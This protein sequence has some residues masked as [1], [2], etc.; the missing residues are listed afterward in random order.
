[1]TTAVAERRTQAERRAA[2]RAKLL[3]AALESLAEL[4]YTG[5]SLPEVVRRAGLSNGGLWRHFRSKAEL[6]AAASLEAEERLLAASRA[7]V[8]EGRSVQERLDT[9]LTQL[10]SWVEQ[11]AMVAIFELLLASRADAELRAAMQASDERA[12]ALFHEEI[13]RL[14]GPDLAAH[15]RFEANVRELGLLLYGIAVT[16]HLRPR[17]ARRA[18]QQELHDL[19]FRLFDVLQS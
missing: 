19:A 4:G 6:M 10:F 13:A 5:A 9:A 2:S 1:M 17:E 18:L 16:H 8:V 3:D 7:A 11:P 15:P 12:G 14:L